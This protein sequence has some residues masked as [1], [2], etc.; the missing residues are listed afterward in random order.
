M[1]VVACCGSLHLSFV[2]P[3]LRGGWGISASI[4]SFFF[5]ASSVLMLL[6]P[7]PSLVM[8]M[9]LW[10]RTDVG[11]FGK[12]VSI[13]DGLAD[14]HVACWEFSFKRV[15]GNGV[16]GKGCILETDVT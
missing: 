16:P 3:E 2:L 8:L 10:W 11:M 15:Y 14:C 12:N 7:L 13:W 4:F 1:Y 9:R 6:P 5:P